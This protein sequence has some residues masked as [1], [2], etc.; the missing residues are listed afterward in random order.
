MVVIARF[1]RLDE[2][3]AAGVPVALGEG[4][5]SSTAAAVDDGPERPGP[6]GKGKR[7]RR[8]G[9]PFP[10]VSTLVL[11]VVAGV[12]WGAVWCDERRRAAEARQQTP[13]AIAMDPDTDTEA[14]TIR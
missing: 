5:L 7:I 1:P 9:V 2:A 10:M 4:R 11:A 14:G 3:E 13:E 8:R 12:L 6:V